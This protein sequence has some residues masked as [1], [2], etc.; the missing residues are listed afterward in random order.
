MK[1]ALVVAALLIAVAEVVLAAESS[2]KA[3]RGGQK[4][5]RE[6]V[7]TTEQMNGA[8]AAADDV[9]VSKF[10]RFCADWMQKLAVRERDNRA[11]MRLLPGPA[12]V[13]GQYVGYAYDS[14]CEVKPRI[15]PKAVPIGKIIYRE[16]TYQ[17]QGS[18]T[19]AAEA[20]SPRVVDQ[21]EITEI[22]RYAK[23]EWVY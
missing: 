11:A 10:N 21:T 5:T 14:R 12:G 9:V 13:Q 3:K 23:G 22:F 18:S 16:V 8:A 1:R 4:R 19:A 7:E 17:Q 15:D 20:N 6:S 2:A